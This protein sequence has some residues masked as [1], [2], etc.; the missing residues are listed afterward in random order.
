V[1]DEA[2]ARMNEQMRQAIHH[3]QNNAHQPTIQGMRDDGLVVDDNRRD[4]ARNSRDELA[5]VV[6]M[7]SS[8]VV[9]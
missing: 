4:I 9:R 2:T 5:L 8:R 3:N 7:P 6:R 1:Y